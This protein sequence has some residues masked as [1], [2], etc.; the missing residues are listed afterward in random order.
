ME[1][2]VIIT[3]QSRKLPVKTKVTALVRKNIKTV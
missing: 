3:M 1:Y 2:G